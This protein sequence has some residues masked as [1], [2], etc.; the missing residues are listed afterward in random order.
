MKWRKGILVLSAAA[1]LAAAVFFGL[2]Q[3]RSASETGALLSVQ[4]PSDTGWETIRC[5]RGE[6]GEYWIFLPAYADLSRMRI[7]SVRTGTEVTMDG[8]RL[9]QGMSCGGFRLDTAYELTWTTGGKTE[10]S[11]I[12]LR[13]SSALPVMY[14]DTRSGSMAYIHQDV[15]NLESGDM[16]LYGEDGSL[17]WS[18]KLRSVSGRGNA[19]WNMEKKPYNLEL[20]E[21]ADL[22]G[23]GTAEN[24]ILLADAYDASHL[25]NKLALELA[26]EVGMAYTP[27]C[28]WVDL[29][30]NG[31]YAGLYLLCE[32]IEV[33]PQR[34]NLSGGNG[35]L[36]SKNWEWRMDA[37]NQTY[38]TTDANAALRVNYATMSLAELDRIWQSAENAIL[39]GDG[40]DPVTGK[41]Y[42]ELIHVDSWAEKYLLEEICANIDA[43]VLSQYFYADESGKIHAGPAWDYDLS[44][45]NQAAWPSQT[46]NMLFANRSGIWGSPWYSALYE[47]EEFY[48]RVTELYQTKFLPVLEELIGTRL[49]TYEERIRQAAAMDQIRW[50]TDDPRQEAQW[51]KTYMSQRMDLLTDLWLEGG[52]YCFVQVRGYDGAALCC[53][54]SP[55]TGLPDLPVYEDT[56]TVDYDGWYCEQTGMPVTPGQPVETDMTVEL[57]YRI[58][59]PEAG[60]ETAQAGTPSRSALGLGIVFFAVFL[61]AVALDRR[62]NWLNSG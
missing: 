46:P 55:G 45:G 29:Y 43:G 10:S 11:R 31:E 53:A 24:W 49:E 6:T 15:D 42:A 14:L 12:T 3:S 56:E 37:R 59:E 36:V 19:T 22:L 20:S 57:R 35:F 2:V 5:W 17:E 27:E 58:L 25:R 48:D 28:T 47:K 30:L 7:H 60:Q 41:S 61:G 40:V 16:R 39:A 8:I 34:V 23:M 54:L 26:R 62:R 51:V 4:V 32:R 50:Q 21:Q 38:I 9:T 18:G 52:Q 1:V 44:M 13:Q 33:H